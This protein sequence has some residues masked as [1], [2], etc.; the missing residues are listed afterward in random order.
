MDG[1]TNG[2]AGVKLPRR[3]RSPL[4]EEDFGLPPPPAPQTEPEV[5][6][7]GPADA[8]LTAARAEAWADGYEAGRAEAEAAGARAL[9]DAAA[10]LG[11]A[12]EGAATAVRADAEATAEALVELLM[13]TFATLFPDL[14][15]RHG[16]AEALAL[17]RALLPGLVYEPSV[18]IALPPAL[19]PALEAELA[20]ALPEEQRAR[21]R[22]RA[23]PGLGA[24]DVR[25]SWERGGAERNTAALWADIQAVLAGA[26]LPLPA[27]AA[28]S[29]PVHA[30]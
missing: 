16:P 4:F 26:G 21:V 5:I 3:A 27:P 19:V 25:V 24:G 23:E 14:C 8:V 30:G 13:E 11:G 18:R 6:A 9:A 15:K 12:L 1:L 10:A 20:R 28:P 29:E 22:V 7:P 17:V 2:F